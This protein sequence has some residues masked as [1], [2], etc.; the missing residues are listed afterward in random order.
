MF[1]I[2][3]Y[4]AC[5]E[6]TFGVG[7]MTT[8]NLHVAVCRLEKQVEQRGESGYEGELW[9]ERSVQVLKRV[10]GDAVP[11]LPEQLMTQRLLYDKALL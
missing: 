5:V 7:P 4:A 2:K 3:V 9:I 10:L 1:D 11:H 6:L 8:S